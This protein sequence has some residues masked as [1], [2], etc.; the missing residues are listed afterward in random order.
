MV[1]T[2]ANLG[3][4]MHVSEN[5]DPLPC[6]PRLFVVEPVHL[7]ECAA[8]YHGVSTITVSLFESA[9][10]ATPATPPENLLSRARKMLTPGMMPVVQLSARERQ[11]LGLL[12]SGQSTAEIA[13]ACYV[14]RD[15]VKT[16]LSK[17]FRKLDVH[18]RAAAVAAA[19]RAGLLDA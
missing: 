11:V 4:P 5:F 14:S 2:L 18:T 8:L 12:A 6:T 9:V 19:S 15:A 10:A 1:A 16:H 17:I 3:I 13:T 7:A